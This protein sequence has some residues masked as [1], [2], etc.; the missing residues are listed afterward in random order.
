MSTEREIQTYTVKAALNRLI[1]TQ[2]LA[3][4]AEADKK[5]HALFRVRVNMLEAHYKDFQKAHA[6]LIRTLEPNQLSEAENISKKADEA[7]FCS[8]AIYQE[9]FPEQSSSVNTSQSNVSSSN[10]KLPKIVLP[11]FDGNL[12]SWQ[13]FRDMF[14]SL[15]HNNNS[16]ENVQKFQYLLSALSGPPLGIISS[17]PLNNNNY[18]IAYELLIKRYQNKRLLASEHWHAIQNSSAITTDAPEMLQKTLDVFQKNLAALDALGLVTKGW[19]FI[20]FNLLW[21][22]LDVESKKAFE[23]EHSKT[24]LPTFEQ[25][26]TFLTEY[27][28]ALVRVKRTSKPISDKSKT[29]NKSH[30]H[31]LKTYTCTNNNQ[32]SC[33]LCQQQHYINQCNKFLGMSPS[34]RL[35]KVKELKLCLN[36]LKFHLVK[37]C[38]SKFNCQ[39][40]NQRHHSLLHLRNAIQSGNNSK[41]TIGD[42]S[43]STSPLHQASTSTSTVLTNLANSQTLLAT[44][45][46]KVADKFGKLHNC[47]CLLDSGSQ[48]NFVTEAFIQ[49]LGL[50]VSSIDF[51]VTGISQSPLNI[52]SKCNLTIHSQYMQFQSTLNCLVLPSI[53]SRL[54]TVSFDRQSM[55][56]PNEIMLADPQFHISHE[57]HMLVGANLFWEIL[58]SGK[59]SL[60]SNMPYLQETKFGW[61]ASGAMVHSKVSTASTCC[62]NTTQIINNDSLSKI[63]TRF[64][65]VE[66]PHSTNSWSLEEKQCENHFVNTYSRDQTGRFIVRIPLNSSVHQ[67][68]DSRQ[69][70]LRRFFSLENKLGRSS[71]VADQYKVFMHEYMTLGHMTPIENDT[72]SFGYY[73]PHHAIIKESISTKL[74]VVF[75][76]SMKT[77]TGISLNDCQLIGPV[78]QNDLLSILLRFRQYQFVLVGDI[79]M[80]YRQIWIDPQD[81]HL[82]R[83]FW[84]SSVSEPLQTYELATVTY[85]TASAPFIATRCLKQLA[86]DHHASHPNA[87]KVISNDFYVDDLITG[88]NSVEALIE[89][90]DQVSM[91][92]NSAGFELRKFMSNNDKILEGVVETDHLQVLHFAENENCKTLGVGWN[93]NKDT[94]LYKI[95]NFGDEIIKPTKRHILS[96]ISSIFDPLGLLS[97]AVV[98]GKMLMQSLWELKLDWDDVIPDNI[99]SNWSK[100]QNELHHLNSIVIPRHVLIQNPIRI[101]LHGFSD[102]SERAYGACVYLRS[103]DSFNNVSVRLLIAKSKVAPLRKVTLPRLELC[104]AFLLTNLTKIVLKSMPEL[105]IHHN[106]YWSDSTIVLN[107]IKSPSNKW[108]TFVAN[109]VSIIQEHTNTNEWHHIQSENNPADIVSRGCTPI[110]LCNSSL[111]WRGPSFLSKLQFELTNSLDSQ[112]DISELPEGKNQNSCCLIASNKSQFDIFTRF[113]NIEKLIRVLAYVLRWKNKTINKIKVNGSLSIR[114]INLT[115]VVLI[116]L[117]QS[118]MFPQEIH[119]FKTHGSINSNSKILSLNPFLDS[120]QLL[121]VG[122]RLCNAQIAYDAKHPIILCHKHIVTK[123]IMEFEHKIQMH[124]G[125]QALLYVVRQRYW[126]TS[127]RNLARKI[128]HNCITCFKI[129]PRSQAPLMGDLPPARVQQSAVFQNVGID[130]AGPFLLKTHKLR[131]HK[132]IKAYVALFICMSTKALHLEVV[133]ELTSDAFLATFRRFIARRG[134][135]SKVFSDNGTNFVGA[136]HDLK[137]LYRLLQCDQIQKDVLQACSKD[138]IEWNFIPAASPNFGGLWESGVKLV[139]YHLRRV[140]GNIH[141]TFEDFYTILVQIEAVVNSRPLSPLSSDPSDIQPLT[142]GHFLICRPLVALPDENYVEQPINR[143]KIYQR[144]QQC[145]QQFWARWNKEYINNLQTRQKWKK[146]HDSLLKLGSL[147]L[148]KEDNLPPMRWKLG[149]VVHVHRGQDNI[150]RVVSLKTSSGTIKRAVNKVCVLPL[151][152]DGQLK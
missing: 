59:M 122:G 4:A 139:K 18:P 96:I 140:L 45:V 129:K 134:K 53:T 147:C 115:K 19:D 151:A 48:S 144:M 64:W 106:F 152:D 97:P 130:Y 21:D 27:V 89:T 116:K 145:M 52:S 14:D 38:N 132:L 67:L 112:I 20:L 126:P 26:E 118:Q 98:V 41:N 51:A 138:S 133:T 90:R 99:L 74:R 75:D 25:L 111:W 57:I 62:F 69:L 82:Q 58:L 137:K 136:N 32:R 11:S 56:I 92:L 105:H 70:A 146:N 127:G 119:S 34:E 6:K 47:R 149:R 142:P 37:N 55:Q 117:A 46:V 135:P 76:A 141:A 107:W 54:P 121:R 85:G 103:V 88:S 101:E 95:R 36:C 2:E 128:V 66:E 24:E 87:S 77:S 124:V 7:Y 71:S 1:E 108:K 109:R 10:V 80:M 84:R 91:I 81:R 5:H 28:N 22:K 35:Q 17:L 102:A 3:S 60:G 150:I 125:P 104:G 15:I 8:Q 49:R 44:A 40:C 79:K 61:I 110:A 113:S 94:I 73:I 78:V 12:K 50:E 143:L 30:N 100:I 86:N 68:S 120:N 9:L 43:I 13:T 29:S 16:L 83:I 42:A 93:A 131:G 23:R 114:E 148:I 63:L 65:E 31:S 72:S 39:Q 123:L 33:A